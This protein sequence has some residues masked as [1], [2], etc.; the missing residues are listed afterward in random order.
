MK[1][2]SE[3]TR[4]EMATELEALRAAHT[5]APKGPRAVYVVDRGWIFAGDASETSDGH[6]R[7]D[8]AVWLFRWE[9]IGFAAA[10]QDWKSDKVDIRN[11]DPVEIPKQ[12]VVFRIPVESGWGKK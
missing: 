6:I 11:I 9:S 4:I 2:T 12:S 5:P 7:L 3:M 10:I 8:N 1:T